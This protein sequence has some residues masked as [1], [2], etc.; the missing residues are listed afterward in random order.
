MSDKSHKPLSKDSL[1]SPERK[2]ITPLRNR[3]DNQKLLDSL[4]RFP[5]YG[6]LLIADPAHPMAKLV[7]GRWDQLNNMTGERF[8]LLAF[9]P[10]EPYSKDFEDGWRKELGGE[11]AQVWDKWN[12]EKASSNDAYDYRRMFD[13]QLIRREDMP[14]LAIFTHPQ[15]ERAAVLPIPNWTEDELWTFLEG[16]CDT[17][18][19][20]ADE[21]DPDKRLQALE[22]GLTSFPA[23]AR[24]KLGH[25]ADGATAY[26]TAHP[27]K[28]V[29]MSLSV[30]VALATG[31]LIPIG[32]AGIGL[33]RDLLGILKSA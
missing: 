26:V 24:Q 16:V 15:A 22:R 23:Q 30:A 5:V 27:V 14:C 6:L 25:L 9:Q 11:F 3:L 20:C 17:I 13:G 7:R 31:H 1:V 33:M 32:A 10:P 19:S 21:P 29:T 4:N 2:I 28:V 8:L 12:N 18:D